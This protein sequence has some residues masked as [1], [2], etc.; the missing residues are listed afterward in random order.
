MIKTPLFRIGVTRADLKHCGKMPDAKEEL[1][2]SVR[3]GRIESRHS[4]NSLERMG[5]SSHDLGAELRKHA[6]TVNCDT[7]SNEEKVAAVVPVTSVEVT[8]SEAMAALSFSTLLAK[9]LMKILG[10]SALW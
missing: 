7:F 2:I 10:R 8:C 3:E 5:S 9:C 4:I 1:N 6:F